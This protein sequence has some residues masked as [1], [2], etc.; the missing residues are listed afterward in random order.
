M[1]FYYYFKGSGFS[2]ITAPVKLH[3]TDLPGKQKTNKVC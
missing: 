3:Q 1:R 2:N